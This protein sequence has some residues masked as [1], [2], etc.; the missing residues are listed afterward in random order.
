MAYERGLNIVIVG[1]GLAGLAAAISLRQNGHHVEIFEQSRF[2]NEIGAA[3]HMTPNATGILKQIGVDPRDSGA[4]HLDQVCL[5]HCL[6][7]PF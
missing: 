2:A 5:L 3:I 6:V 1:G 4:V 7:A